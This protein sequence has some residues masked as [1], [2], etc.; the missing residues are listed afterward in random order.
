MFAYN[1]IPH[2]VKNYTPFV[3]LYGHQATLL[4]ALSLLL[5]PTYTYDN[6]T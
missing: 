6:Y 4:M 5:K 1:T 2:M 3:L